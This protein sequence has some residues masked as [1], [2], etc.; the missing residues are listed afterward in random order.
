VLVDKPGMQRVIRRFCR[1]QT[2]DPDDP[3]ADSI[4]VVREPVRALRAQSGGARLS[5]VVGRVLPPEP[6]R[7]P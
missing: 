6:G 7:A 5:V 2:L 3:A 4:S 1:G